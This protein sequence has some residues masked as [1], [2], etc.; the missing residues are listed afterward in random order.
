[1]NLFANFS[2]DRTLTSVGVGLSQ[3]SS[4]T[5]QITNT[6]SGSNIQIGS[7]QIPF[8]K[9]LKNLKSFQISSTGTVTFKT[10]QSATNFDDSKIT[11]DTSI[12]MAYTRANTVVNFGSL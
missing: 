1:M 3:T 10:G 6:V 9:F 4:F 8:E 7:S 12:P 11:L 5:L 2:S